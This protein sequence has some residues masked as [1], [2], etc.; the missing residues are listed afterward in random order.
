MAKT[1]TEWF[2]E[3]CGW[4]REPCCDCGGHGLVSVYSSED[5]LGAGECRTC[6]G[7]GAIWKTPHGRLRNKPGGA[8]C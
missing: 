2:R 5:F 3:Q 1:V 4:R 6:N 7:T 8:F